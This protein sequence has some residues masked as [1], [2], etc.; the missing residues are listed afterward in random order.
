VPGGLGPQHVNVAQQRRDPAS[1]W[2]FMRN[3]ISTYRSCPELGWG[4]FELLDQPHRQVLAHR[5]AWEDAAVVIVHN[6]GA[7]PVSVPLTVGTGAVELADLLGDDD[8]TSDDRG[9]IELNLDG[10]GFRWLRVHPAGAA[11]LP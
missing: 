5:C 1:L 7:E 4:G 6:L 3:L 2:T 10:Y 11:R 8:V 9:R